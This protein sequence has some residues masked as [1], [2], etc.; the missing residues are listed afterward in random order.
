MNLYVKQTNGRY[1]IAEAGVI[2]SAASAIPPQIERGTVVGSPSD[3]INVLR[4]HFAG[5][6][7]ESM[8]AI[9]LD[10]RHRVMDTET[11]AVGTID[12]ASVYPREVVK[13]GLRLNAAAIIIAHNHPSGEA[14]PSHADRQITR[15]LQDALALVDVRFLD[16]FVLG[17]SEHTSFAERGLI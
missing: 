11:I 9:W 10:N 5:K 16:H 1:S 17:T 15:R 12:G 4:E 14:E 2:I 6:E 7:R 8:V 13:S 3:S